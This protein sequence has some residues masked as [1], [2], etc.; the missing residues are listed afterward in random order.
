VA[1]LESP[2]GLGANRRISIRREGVKKES[3]AAICISSSFGT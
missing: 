1:G 3:I 2:N